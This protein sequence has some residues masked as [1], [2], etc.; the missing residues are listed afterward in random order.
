[1]H[2]PYSFAYSGNKLSE[3]G[4]AIMLFLDGQLQPF[5]IGE[6]DSLQNVHI[7]YPEETNGSKT[8][9]IDLIFIPISG[10]SGDTLDLTIISRQYPD[11]KWDQN[12]VGSN[13]NIS[14]IST[15]LKLFHTPPESTRPVFM[16]PPLDWSSICTDAPSRARS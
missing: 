12:E 16:V 14:Q 5:R 13:E 2:L 11:W 6:S 15:R 7:L 1:M 10:N 4:L 8:V 9:T 3:Y